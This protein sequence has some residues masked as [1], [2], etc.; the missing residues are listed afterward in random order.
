MTQADT[1]VIAREEYDRLLCARD[2]LD[3]LRALAAY[4]TAP[5]DGM[6]HA[7]VTRLIDGEAPLRVIRD[8]RGLSQ[9]ALAR[10]SGVNRVQ[11]ADIE[12]GR[13]TGS[14]ETLKKL[15]QTLDVTIDE[16]V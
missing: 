8:W 5:E 7:F 16:L 1:I 13:A 12:A 15:A 14:V 2:E 11:I 10:M 9:S 3:D 4:R 6:P